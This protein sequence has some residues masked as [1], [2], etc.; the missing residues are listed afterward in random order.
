M[1]SN[2]GQKPGMSAS[3]PRPDPAD[4]TSEFELPPEETGRV[5][6]TVMRVEPHWFGIAPAPLLLGVAAVCF[7]AAIGLFATGH[8]PYGLILLGLGALLL[9]AYSEAARRRPRSASESVRPTTG[10]AAVA[11]AGSVWESLRA[12]AAASAHAK[13]IH[14][15]LFV[16]ESERRAALLDLGTAVYL[17]DEG[18]AGAARTRL[19]EIDA[20]ETDL[21]RELHDGLAEAGERI[22]RVRL[23]VQQTEMVLPVEPAPPPDEATPPQPAVVPEPYPPPDEADLPT[24]DPPPDE[25]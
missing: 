23:A 1:R 14:S 4:Q 12:Q 21:R 2:R 6:V 10:S 9:A 24:P 15:G 17:H 11:R 7:V 13:R 20:H 19:A 18:A 22:R 25:E 5:P 3:A 8:W 16:V